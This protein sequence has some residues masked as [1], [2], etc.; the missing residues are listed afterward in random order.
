[1]KNRFV[2]RRCLLL[3]LSISFLFLSGC[4]EGLMANLGFDTHDYRGETV[5][6]VHASDSEIARTLAEMT[7]TLTVASPL[8]PSFSGAKGAAEVCRDAVLNHM[9]ENGY[10]QYAGNAA[11]LRKAADSYPQMQLSVLIPAEDF[12]ST[13]YAT[14]GGREKITNKNGTLFL[15]LD[16]VEAYTTAALP[17]K[18]Q[19][20]TIVTLLEETERTYRLYFMNT[21]DAVTSPEYF[22][23]IIKREDGSLYFSELTESKRK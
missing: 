18:S 17:Q 19:V 4:G 8:L 2:F 1:M 13:V 22:A 23:L 21:L 5:T 3:L 9:L 16:K 20:Q 14:F 15:Y 7:R 11:L 10:A 6:F 12:E